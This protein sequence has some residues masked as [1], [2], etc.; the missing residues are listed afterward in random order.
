MINRD[1]WKQTKKYLEYRAS[2][3]QIGNGSLGIE[4]THVRYLLEW[5][6]ETPFSKAKD[7]R[8]TLPEFLQNGGLEGQ[9]KPLSEGYLKKILATARRFFLW[10]SEN[11]SGYTHLNHT[12]R[13]TLKTKRMAQIPKTREV[14]TY[15]DI[16]KMAS[17]PVNTLSE[18]RIQAAAAFLYLSGMRIGAFISLP[19]LAV[20]ITNRTV[21]QHPCLG[22][23]TKNRKHATTF[24]WEIP[25]LM[26]V[27]QEWDNLVRSVLP[28]QGYWFAPFSPE[29]GKIDPSNL[30]CP[31]SRRS[32]VTR[33]LKQWENFH[34]IQ[35]YSP[36]KF[37]HGHIHYGLKRAKTIADYKAVS[38]NVMHSNMSVTDEFYSNFNENELRN[39]ISDIGKQPE[40]GES[41]KDLFKKFEAFLKW[42][43]SQS[44]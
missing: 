10:L 16:Q 27:I 20:D 8:P 11:K 32:L 14:V 23:R 13:S 40:Q 31:E 4:T 2:V 29:T 6:Q 35:E 34:G 21:K 17:L 41:Q 18:K 43:Q 42:E 15:E 36:H 9:E 7:K 3:D 28:D 12:W 26:Q 24:L 37:R 25:E 19:L 22:V 1:N 5:L 38:E 44:C 39:R 30:S 33:Q